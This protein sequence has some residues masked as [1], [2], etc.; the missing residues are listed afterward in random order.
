M[1]VIVFITRLLDLISRLGK[2]PRKADTFVEIVV[3]DSTGSRTYSGLL[4]NMAVTAELPDAV[5][6]RIEVD[7]SDRHSV[8]SNDYPLIT[9]TDPNRELVVF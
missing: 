3:N 9:S 1:P 7:A 6:V 4:C 5:A 2:C 8:S